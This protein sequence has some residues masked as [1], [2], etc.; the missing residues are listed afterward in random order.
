MDRY[1]ILCFISLAYILRG[2]KKH[3]QKYTHTMVPTLFI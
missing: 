3:I 1:K 2:K